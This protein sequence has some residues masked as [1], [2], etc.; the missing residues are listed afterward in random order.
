[1]KECRGVCQS[2]A[3]TPAHKYSTS[4]SFQLLHSST[5]P[6]SLLSFRLVS[7]VQATVRRAGTKQPTQFWLS[8]H[9][10]SSELWGIWILSCYFSGICGDEALDDGW[11]NGLRNF[12]VCSKDT[13][14]L[15]SKMSSIIHHN[16]ILKIRMDFSEEPVCTPA[17][18]HTFRAT[19]KQ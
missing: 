7:R 11:L 2:C 6:S 10:K 19:H 17:G 4:T 12:T 18:Y 1:M 9:A 8:G 15:S 5:F 3:H 14:H 13:H 16:T